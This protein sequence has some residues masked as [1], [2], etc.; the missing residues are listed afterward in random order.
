MR[1]RYR[2]IYIYNIYRNQYLIKFS[3]SIF[4]LNSP[5]L[6]TSTHRHNFQQQ[7][8]NA[9]QEKLVPTG[10]NINHSDTKK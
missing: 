4:N 10:E 1:K 2:L 8:I 6:E 3:Q 5:T 9:K 7:H